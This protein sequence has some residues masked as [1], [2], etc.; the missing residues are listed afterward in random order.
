MRPGLKPASGRRTIY[1]VTVAACAWIGLI[2]AAHAET[3]ASQSLLT[4]AA[5]IPEYHAGDVA[6]QDVVASFEFAVVDSERTERLRE[7]ELAKVPAIFRFDRWVAVQAEEKFARSFTRARTEFLETMEVASHRKKL[8][9]A[10]VAHS[11]FW[12]FVDWFKR[13]HPEFPLSTNLARAWALGETEGDIQFELQSCLRDITSRYIRSDTVPPR[14]DTMEVELVICDD[15]NARLSLGGIQAQTE[16]IS[17]TQIWSLSE[18]R[19]EALRRLG[20]YGEDFAKL[21]A[22]SIKENLSFDD[23]LTRQKRRSRAAELVAFEQ[24]SPGQV[25]VRSGQII[26]SNTKAALDVLS[27]ALKRQQGRTTVPPAV[28]W[29]N[30]KF[31]VFN[32]HPFI[33][34]AVALV[35]PT[36][37]LLWALFRRRPSSTAGPICEAYTVVMNPARNETIFLPASGATTGITDGSLQLSIAQPQVMTMQWQGQFREAEQRAEE[38]LALVR[39]GLAPHLAKELTHK[40]VQELASQRTALLRAHQLAEEEILA[41]EARFEKVCRELQDRVSSYERRTAELEKELVSKAEETRQLMNATILLTQEKLAK[42]KASEPFA[43][44]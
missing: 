43:C 40:L 38:L 34:V 15:P 32:V 30:F 13:G 19:D 26:D 14:A 17:R 20:P 3:T 31:S 23:W 44:N 41:L 1:S 35:A 39:A 10:T 37:L 2:C 8:D 22:S 6:T 11:S 33:L 16:V 29:R 5:T 27:A 36:L 18:A 25:I 4:S 7:Q 12:R 21:V 42:G 24:Y 9:D 28:R